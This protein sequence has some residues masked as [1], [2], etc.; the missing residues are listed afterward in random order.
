MFL[1]VSTTLLIRPVRK[2]RVPVRRRSEV[3]FEEDEREGRRESQERD[4]GGVGGRGLRS[5]HSFLTCV[6]SSKF[7]LIDWGKGFS[8]KTGG[9]TL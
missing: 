1:P 8:I 6:Y 4:L 9:R 7:L 2:E 5:L 3:G